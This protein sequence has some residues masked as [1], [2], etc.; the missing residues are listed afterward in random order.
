MAPSPSSSPWAPSW[1]WVSLQNQWF[2]MAHEDRVGF[3][4]RG[5]PVLLGESTWT[6]SPSPRELAHRPVPDWLGKAWSLAEPQSQEG[7]KRVVRG[8]DAS[9]AR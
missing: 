4:V 9:S 8:W 2:L 1:G 3:R 6:L 5:F 7:G